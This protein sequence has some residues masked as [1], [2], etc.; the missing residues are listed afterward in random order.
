M[1]DKPLDVYLNEYNSLRAEQLMRIQTQFNAV[2]WLFTIIGA[3]LAAVTFTYEKIHVD[4]V[5]LMR[6]GTVL[7]PLA[8]S[9]IAFMGFDHTIMVHRVG[10]YVVNEL[11]PAIVRWLN[12][13]SC[14]PILHWD[15]VAGAPAGTITAIRYYFF[16]LGSWL[17]YF[18]LIPV[19]TFFATISSGWWRWPYLGLVISDWVLTIAFG[20]CSIAVWNER[21][22]WLKLK[23]I[24]LPF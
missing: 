2:T 7:L 5:S 14:E 8:A 15:P 19:A 3:L 11:R 21:A 23:P 16:F 24:R 4:L 1:A 17:F 6:W 12:D 22:L 13:P 18:L 10:A 20:Y 9:P